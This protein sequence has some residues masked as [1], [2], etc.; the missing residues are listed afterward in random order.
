MISRAHINGRHFDLMKRLVSSDV[1]LP[2]SDALVDLMQF[3][4]AAYRG[5]KYVATP[6]GLTAYRTWTEAEIQ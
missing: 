5:G 3:G 1:E 2:L 4:Y 6:A